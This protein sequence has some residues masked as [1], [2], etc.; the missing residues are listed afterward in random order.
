MRPKNKPM[1]RQYS[2]FLFLLLW[3]TF[4]PSQ[5]QPDPAV[6]D[7][8]VRSAVAEQAFEG[9]VL[10][11]DRGEVIFHQAFGYRDLEQTKPTRKDT[12]FGIASITKLFTAIV[13]LQLVEEGKLALT[14]DLNTLFP[15]WDIPRAKRITVHHL[16]LHISG[17]PNESDTIYQS[18]RSA[19][20][21]VRETL[22]QPGS[23]FGAFNYANIDY[24]LLGLLIERYTGKPW[25]QAVQERIL[26][27]AAMPD[28]G[29]LAMGQYPPNYARTFSYGEGQERR[30]DPAFHIENFHAAGCMYATAGDLLR[31]DQALYG[32]SLL[33]QASQERLYTSYPEYNYSGYSVWTY[34]YPFSASQ[35]RVMERRGGI[36]GANSV[37]VRLLDLNRTLIILSNNDRF[38]PDSFGDTASLKEALMIAMDVSG[39]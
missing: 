35:P 1:R 7:S 4:T 32:E 25:R 17:L 31:L 34:A 26:D 12:H 11:A 15:E 29:F 38:D 13:L 3:G 8:I 20:E 21:F 39:G 14:D 6:L 9:T 22:G 33:S 18:T 19:E 28:T 10:V 37:L 36:L 2:A 27:R 24:V 16:L 23:R 5:A 30:P